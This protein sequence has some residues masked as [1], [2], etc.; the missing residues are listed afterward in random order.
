MVF[1]FI[2]FWIFGW[3][4]QRSSRSFFFNMYTWH[5]YWI[6]IYF[7]QVFTRSC[8]TVA[9]HSSGWWSRLAWRKCRMINL[10]PW[11]CH[12][13]WSGQARGRCRMIKLLK[14]L[15][16]ELDDKRGTTIGTKFSVHC[17]RIPFL[18]EMWFLTVD[19]F[20]RIYV[21]IAKLS[22][23]QYCWRVFEDFHSQEYVHFFDKLLPHASALLHWRLWL[24]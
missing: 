17:I 11:R 20:I 1:V 9:W 19:P 10:L 14:S 5:R 7:T 22:K 4:D 23:R 15:D 3:L 21:F 6:G 2:W 13:C 8:L 24:S 16:E 18:N 12:G